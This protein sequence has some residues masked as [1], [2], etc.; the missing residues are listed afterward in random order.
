MNSE[1]YI[2]LDEVEKNKKNRNEL[3]LEQK[4]LLKDLNPEFVNEDN[5]YKELLTDIT[6]RVV[7]MCGRDGTIK[8]RRFSRNLLDNDIAI[9]S[10]MI[11]TYIKA[12]GYDN[13]E[14]NVIDFKSC[15]TMDQA[16]SSDDEKT[17]RRETSKDRKKTLKHFPFEIKDN[18]I[19]WCKKS[20]ELL[21]KYDNYDIFDLKNDIKKTKN[22]ITKYG[23]YKTKKILDAIKEAS[24]EEVSHKKRMEENELYRILTLPFEKNKSYGIEFNG[25]E[26]ENI[27]CLD[28]ILGIGLTNAIY[29]GSVGVKKRQQLEGIEESIEGWLDDIIELLIEIPCLNIRNKLAEKIIKYV[30]QAKE[31]Y[32]HIKEI[33]KEHVKEAKK[34]LEK[35]ITSI[36]DIWKIKVQLNIYDWYEMEQEEKNEYEEE[37]KGRSEEYA[38]LLLKDERDMH[39]DFAYDLGWDLLHIKDDCTYIYPYTEELQEKYAKELESQEKVYYKENIRGTIGK[40]VGKIIEPKTN[41]DNAKKIYSIIH[42]KVMARLIETFPIVK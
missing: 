14:N 31:K 28:Y 38:M 26:V 30:I 22:D 34:A 4:K 40:E 15:V 20:Q 12:G 35:I 10:Y 11:I 8:K 37:M 3:E 7:D 1:L 25:D 17:N 13:K 19:N 9:I 27:L 16:S 36:K 33:D 5:L 32:S 2:T 21:Y 6:Y 39:I 42:M 18:M 41:L 23:F 29:Q 24:I